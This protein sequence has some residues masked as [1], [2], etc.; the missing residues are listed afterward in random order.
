MDT[1]IR[2][3]FFFFLF[4]AVVVTGLIWLIDARL[5]K[6]KRLAN[7]E[8]GEL[9]ADPVLAEYAKSFFPIILIVLVL[10]SFLVEPFKIPSGSM[11]G[12]SSIS[13]R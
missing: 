8:E 13:S 3:D 1:G 11:M 10:R 7:S 5:F 4:T 2:F 12:L 9:P 6:P